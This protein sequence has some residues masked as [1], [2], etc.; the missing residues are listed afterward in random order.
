[1]Y[2]Q[3]PGQLDANAESSESLTYSMEMK[4]LLN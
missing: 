3:L 2:N 1:M 4:G